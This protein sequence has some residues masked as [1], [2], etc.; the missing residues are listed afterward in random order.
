MDRGAAV[1]GEGMFD[2]GGEPGVE[3]ARQLALGLANGI[4]ADLGDTTTEWRMYRKADDTAV[5]PE[6]MTEDELWD[7]Y[8]AGEIYEVQV[9][10]D[11]E[12]VSATL[13]VGQPAF[14]QARI[15]PV[16]DYVSPAD[17][18]PYDAGRLRPQ[19]AARRLH[20]PAFDGL[21]PI[22]ITRREGLGH[23]GT[24]PTGDDP[25][26]HTGGLVASPPAQ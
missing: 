16:Y 7:L 17:A 1:M 6:T 21:T 10:T 20:R 8:D 23:A 22:T 19:P 18:V 9:T 5:D 4:S 11:F 13:A 24:T 15:V 2:L 14:D 26:C 25:A 3:A 12:I